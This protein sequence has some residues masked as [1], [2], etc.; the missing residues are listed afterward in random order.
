MKNKQKL[1][2]IILYGIIVFLCIQSLLLTLENRNLRWEKN[3]LH[4]LLYT[5][6]AS[7]PQKQ[8][9]MMLPGISIQDIKSGKREG[10]LE[11]VKREKLLLFVFSTDCL[12]CD[13][14]AEIWNEVYEE[15]AGQIMIL[16]ISKG[17]ILAIEDY[18]QRNNI[19]FPVFRYESALEF[20]IFTSLPQTVLAEKSGKI[21][22]ILDGIP[23]QLKNQ[24]KMGK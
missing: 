15:F 19:Q 20:D 17:D 2:D 12:A 16:G 23:D 5:P 22:S 7:V 4:F 24:I 21:I 18:V 10:I 14:A 9:S 6:T 8:K 1:K 13:Q 11:A 3:K